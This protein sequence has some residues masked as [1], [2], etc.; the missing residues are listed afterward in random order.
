MGSDDTAGRAGRVSELITPEVGII[1]NTAVRMSSSSKSCL[2]GDCCSEDVT[3]A[4]HASCP[5]ELKS[6]TESESLLFVIVTDGHAQLS[7]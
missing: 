1:A 7:W 6:E 5:K 4:G 3:V 2:D